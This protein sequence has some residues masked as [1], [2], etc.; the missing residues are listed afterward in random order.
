MHMGYEER[1]TRCKDKSDCDDFVVAMAYV[2]WQEWGRLCN[3]DEGFQ[4]GTIF[5]ELQK[6][7]LCYKR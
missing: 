3:L 2:P 4:E 5:K 1:C 7:F 6:P